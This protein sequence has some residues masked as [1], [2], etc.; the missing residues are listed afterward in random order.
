MVDCVV[1]AVTEQ[2]RGV[3]G[4]CESDEEDEAG[5]VITCEAKLKSIALLLRANESRTEIDLEL[6]R[7]LL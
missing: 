4:R 7:R 3:G 6:L 5:P 1:M 2:G